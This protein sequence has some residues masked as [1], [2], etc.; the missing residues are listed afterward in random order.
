[1]LEIADAKDNNKLQD[2]FKNS[3]IIASLN[4]PMQCMSKG[5]CAR[6]LQ[7]KK[8]HNNQWQYFY[9][10]ANQDQELDNVDLQHLKWRCQQNNLWEKTAKIYSNI[11]F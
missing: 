4:A 1:M 7:R 2:Y 5:I 11:F 6:C 3:K 10:C 8:D 9:A